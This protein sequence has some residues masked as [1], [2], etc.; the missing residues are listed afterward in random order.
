MRPYATSR[1]LRSA[2]LPAL[3]VGAIAL[4]TTGC[5]EDEGPGTLV[6]RYEFGGGSSCQDA[7]VEYVEATLDDTE[8]STTAECD[9]SFEVRLN[10][11]P[12]GRYSITLQGQ[13]EQ[14]IDGEPVSVVDNL[15]LADADRRVEVLG[16]TTVESDEFQLLEAPAQLAVAVNLGAFSC[17]NTGIDHF[18]VDAY[19]AGGFT[20]RILQSELPCDG[21]IDMEDL[22]ITAGALRAQ[23]DV[24]RSVARDTLAENFERAAEM[25]RLPQQEIMTIYELLRPGRAR[26]RDE[27]AATAERLRTA[28]DAPRL[29]AFVDEAAGLYQKRGLFRTRY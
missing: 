15:Y 23:A 9:G 7:G 24:A 18:V 8:Y 1:F 12:A 5:G 6:V 25:T 26:S 16:D 10:D 3:A 11:V 2:L 29:A 27:L 13:L 17:S 14:A 4:G 21:E 28:F 20:D 19:E 22:R